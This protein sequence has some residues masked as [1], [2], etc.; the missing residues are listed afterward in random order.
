MIGHPL[1]CTDDVLKRHFDIRTR[2]PTRKI[3]LAQVKSR[4]LAIE[5]VTDRTM[6]MERWVTWL[7]L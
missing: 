6:G 3:P 2:L 7:D 4:I 5:L 1:P